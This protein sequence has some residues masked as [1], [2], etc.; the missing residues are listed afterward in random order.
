MDERCVVDGEGFACECP[1]GF[2]R[3]DEAWR[4][5][6]R[7]GVTEWSRRDDRAGRWPVPAELLQ[8]TRAP[9]D[10]LYELLGWLES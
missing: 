3:R 2:E 5:A 10:A 7:V 6:A 8:G 1:P 4:I 9:D